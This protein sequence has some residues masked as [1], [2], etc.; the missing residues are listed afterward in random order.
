M[1]LHDAEACCIGVSVAADA[2]AASKSVSIV[3]VSGHR[4]K[5]AAWGHLGL[6]CFVDTSLSLMG[7]C[8]RET[9]AY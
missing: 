8:V 1:M 9:K 6:I 5:K 2:D 7:K 3:A 4:C